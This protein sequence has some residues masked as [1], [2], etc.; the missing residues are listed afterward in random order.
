MSE[1]ATAKLEPGAGVNPDKVIRVGKRLRNWHRKERKRWTNGADAKASTRQ[2]ARF[3]ASAPTS[4]LAHKETA[5]IA[6]AWLAHK[7]LKP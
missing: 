1:T 3:L 7:G 4:D 2:Y 5:A 6:K